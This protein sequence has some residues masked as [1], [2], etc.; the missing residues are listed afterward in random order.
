MCNTEQV[1]HLLSGTC[2]IPS[3][4]YEVVHSQV[5]QEQDRVPG[6]RVLHLFLLLEQ[7]WLGRSGI[8]E[9]MQWAYYIEFMAAIRKSLLTLVSIHS[10][11]FHKAVHSVL[12]KLLYNHVS[13]AEV[14]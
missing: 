14:E 4:C 5:E 8:S 6:G 12:N 9:N 2:L 7:T 11:K 1:Q 13:T 10:R 3:F